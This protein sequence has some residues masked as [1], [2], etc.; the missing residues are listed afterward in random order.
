MV[1]RCVKVATLWTQNLGPEM[2]VFELNSLNG[3]ACTYIRWIRVGVTQQ[4]LRLPGIFSLFPIRS[5]LILLQRHAGARQKRL[6][7]PTH[8]RR[9]NMSKVHNRNRSGEKINYVLKLLHDL[10]RIEFC[11]SLE[12]SDQPC[13]LR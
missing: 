9:F 7:R 13:Q 11:L 2:E 3:I 8:W 5:C 6:F 1:I 4:K 10:R 12:S